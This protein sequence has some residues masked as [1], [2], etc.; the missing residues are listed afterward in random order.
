MSTA[1]FSGANVYPIFSDN[2]GAPLD[3][4]YVYIGT[5]GSEAESSAISVFWDPALTIPAVQ[6]IRTIA[7]RPARSGTPAQFYIG[8]SDYSITIRD[9]NKSLV[10]ATTNVADKMYMPATQVSYLR[11]A[12]GAVQTTMSAIYDTVI[13]VKAMFGAV[14]DGVTDDTAAIRAACTA[15]QTA[16]GGVL[17]FGG[18]ENNYLI[19]PGT[20][21]AEPAALGDF[22][23]INGIRFL[24]AG[25]KFT[26]SGT[27]DAGIR[28]KLFKFTGCKNIAFGDF[29]GECT[30]SRSGDIYNRG[31][32]FAYFLNTNSNLSSGSLTITNFSMGFHFDNQAYEVH[33]KTVPPSITTNSTSFVDI[34]S[35][36]ADT[37]GYP[38]VHAGSGHYITAKIYANACGRSYFVQD[39]LNAK[40]RIQSK[41][42]AAS[43]DVG[44]SGFLE[45]IDIDYSNT[46]STINL[47]GD[48]ISILY[49]ATSEYTGSHNKNI[50]I[51]LNCRFTNQVDY[52]NV[53][54]LAT[55]VGSDPATRDAAQEFYNIN[56]SGMVDDSAN[57]MYPLEVEFPAAWAAASNIYSLTIEDFFANSTVSNVDLRG[58]VD[59]ATLKNIKTTADLRLWPSTAGRIAAYNVEAP[60]FFDASS[61]SLPGQV[62]LY[63]CNIT[64]GSHF[65]YGAATRNLYNSIITSGGGR[66]TL[67]MIGQQLQSFSICITNT[68]GTLQHRVVRSRF[69]TSIPDA[70]LY[71]MFSGF[72][73][74]LA[75][76]PTIGPSTDFT[77][78]VGYYS[79]NPQIVLNNRNAQTD[80]N[81]CYIAHVQYYDG[82]V[83]TP[84]VEAITSNTDVNGVTIE[85]T[86]IAIRNALDGS[87]WNLNTTNIPTGKSLYIKVLGWVA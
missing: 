18:S 33:P 12:T 54:R 71:S 50:N 73:A 58:L 48:C 81:V 43:N 67:D 62:D 20:I 23:S 56:I 4:G 39:V 64:S 79:S 25:A 84:L 2:T 24:S 1:M 85:R 66:S 35:V 37:T 63:S 11:N 13:D 61:K 26:I 38:I 22:S 17:D 55:G 69:S 80:A 86:H 10:Y 76:L 5:A 9:R 59:V 74:T 15:V 47:P 70:Q 16:G 53:F 60:E 68:A 75:N 44:L 57:R 36:I 19:Y 87:A 27:F 49:N 46:E 78:G 83:S 8:A 77:N 7:G 51:K 14:G 41:D 40:V 65:D 6:P 3:T 42:Y 29:R 72:S 45:N 30:S 82:A 31:P 21:S 34:D 52:Q 28:A 32:V